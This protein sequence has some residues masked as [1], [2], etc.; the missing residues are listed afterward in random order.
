MGNPPYNAIQVSFNDA[1]PTDKYPEIDTKIKETW[2]NTK[3]KKASTMYDMYKRF[4]K[5]SSERIKKN[6]MV[7][8]ITNNSFLDAKSDDGFRRAVYEE[9]DYIYT[10]NLKG[11]QNIE[12]WKKQG[13]KIFGSKAKIGIA[14]SFFIKTGEGKSKIHYAQVD[15]GMKREEKLKWLA[16]NSLF[17]LIK[18]YAIRQKCQWLNQRNMILMN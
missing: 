2:G 7:V 1:N 9:F 4:L 17:T 11:N 12:N 10:V 8:F 15:D 18:A 14:I 6:G 3:V 5:W 16:D 13:G